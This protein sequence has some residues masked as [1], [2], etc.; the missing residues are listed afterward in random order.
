MKVPRVVCHHNVLRSGL[1][2]DLHSYLYALCRELKI[3]EAYHLAEQGQKNPCIPMIMAGF[4]LE[5]RL[6]RTS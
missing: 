3:V 5:V 4:P 1:V 2:D 6:S